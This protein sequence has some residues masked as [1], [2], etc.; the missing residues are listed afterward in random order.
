M[1]ALTI[2]VALL[3]K[4]ALVVWLSKRGLWP[5]WEALAAEKA[6]EKQVLLA[7]KEWRKNGGPKPRASTTSSTATVNDLLPEGTR[8]IR[9]VR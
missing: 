2:F 7:Y 9:P 8:P 4:G 5:D 3:L 1:T 6:E